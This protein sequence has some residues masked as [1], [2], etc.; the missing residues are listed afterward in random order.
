M[1]D[2]ARP[3]TTVELIE[4]CMR[5]AE[6]CE[7][8]IPVLPMK[9]TIYQSA[10][11]RRLSSCLPREQLVAGQ[12]PEVFRFGKYLAANER[13]LPDAI[14]TINGS[15]E[16]ALLAGMEIAMIP[17]DE[18]NYKITTK[19]DLIRFCEEMEWKTE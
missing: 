5:A 1:Q 13:L 3:N 18:S 12:A 8:A 4:A 6:D 10:D 19:A 2:A 11:G 17:G 14:L 7:G 9:D 16:P 15:T